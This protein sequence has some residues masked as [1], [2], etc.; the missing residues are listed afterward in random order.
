VQTGE[1]WRR[2]K[3]HGTQKTV[4]EE[5]KVTRKESCRLE[6]GDG[7]KGKRGKNKRRGMKTG[8]GGGREKK[9]EGR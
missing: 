5:R 1:G 2:E 3:E 7:E 4:G 8:E 6:K 9:E